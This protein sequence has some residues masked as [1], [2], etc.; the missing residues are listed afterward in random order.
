QRVEEWLAQWKKRG[1]RTASKKPVKNVDLWQ[2]LDQLVSQHQISWQWVKGHSGHL[3]NERVDE[4][5]NQGVDEVLQ[6][7]AVSR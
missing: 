1:W 7:Q 6:Q 5:A 4:L 3:E 2:T